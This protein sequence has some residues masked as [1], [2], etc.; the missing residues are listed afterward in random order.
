MDE[1][2]STSKISAL[3]PMASKNVKDPSVTEKWLTIAFLKKF[4]HALTQ[5]LLSPIAFTD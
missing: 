3:P 1:V 5:G 2:G 4:E